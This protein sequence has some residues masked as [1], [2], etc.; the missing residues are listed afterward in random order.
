MTSPTGSV[1]GPLES[2]PRPVGDHSRGEPQRG[3]AVVATVRRHEVRVDQALDSGGTDEAPSP[4]ELFVVSLDTCV[5]YFAGQYL[6]RHGVDRA[7]L[8][9][10]AEYRKT[11]RPPRVASISLRVIV[12][13]G[14]RRCRPD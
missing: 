2:R 7:G 13:A 11:N 1:R 12:P 14:S 10:H 9:V 4:V 8:A 6:E 5:A 3:H